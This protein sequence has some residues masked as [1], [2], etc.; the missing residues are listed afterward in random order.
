MGGGTNSLALSAEDVA[1]DTETH[2][3]ALS[4]KQRLYVE[5]RLNGMAPRAAITASGLAPSTK[6]YDMENHPRIRLVMHSLTRDA[7][8]G[9]TMVRQDV[10]QGL[11]DAVDSAATSTELVMAWREIG[12]I[13]GAY[14]PTVVRHEYKDITPEK[15]SEM[16]DADLLKMAAQ[17]NF[18]LTEEDAIEAEF[19]EVPEGEPEVVEKATETPV[20][21]EKVAIE[22]E[23]QPLRADK[24]PLDALESSDD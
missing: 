17:E 6:V 19:T 8:K 9:L 12:K 16:S 5:N 3:L 21:V 18:K 23:K 13:I 10:L 11:L 15:M 24:E 14:E 22:V 7:L 1:Q 4:A 2:L 20:E